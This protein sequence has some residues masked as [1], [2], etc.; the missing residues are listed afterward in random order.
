MS[1][2]AS[3]YLL[4]E[5]AAEEIVA[6]I[7][8]AAAGGRY[9]SPALS[10]FAAQRA[11]RETALRADHPEVAQLSPAELNVLK[12]TGENQTTK[13]MAGLL[14]VSPHMVDSH[15]ASISAKLGLQGSRS[16]LRF[17]FE[18]CREL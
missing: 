14:R 9:L 1:A 4:K 3:A 8:T 15:R 17:A 2:G 7:R 12:P 16:L 10:D 13:E 11:A 6:A 5:R 18:H